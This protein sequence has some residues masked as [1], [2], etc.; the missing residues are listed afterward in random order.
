M[1][2][3]KTSSHST[4]TS[5]ILNKYSHLFTPIIK[6]A[7]EQQ[8][9]LFPLAAQYSNFYLPSGVIKN[10]SDDELGNFILDG[11]NINY[12]HELLTRIL[13]NPEIHW[14]ASIDDFSFTLELSKST[15]KKMKATHKRLMQIVDVKIKHQVGGELSNLYKRFWLYEFSSGGEIR[16]HFD[17]VDKEDSKGANPREAEVMRSSRISFRLSSLGFDN[18]RV[19]LS[20]LRGASN[21]EYDKAVK[22]MGVAKK[23]TTQGAFVTRCDLESKFYGLPFVFLLTED[24]Y[25]NLVHNAVFPDCTESTMAESYY[26]G[27]HEN[28]THFI[29]Y[30]VILGLIKK[31]VISVDHAMGLV[32]L[33]KMERRI[34]PSKDGNGGTLISEL[35]KLESHYSRLRFY[36][37]RVFS[38]LPVK[39]ALKLARHKVNRVWEH[40]GKQE[41][42][43]LKK[44]LDDPTYHINL[45]AEQVK[46][47]YFTLLDKL[48]NIIMSPA[49][50]AETPSAMRFQVKYKRRKVG[51]RTKVAC[52][53][54]NK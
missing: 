31:G 9:R 25:P 10:L 52:K 13:Q 24:T 2:S 38:A 41:T 14:D 18:L 46:M 11:D 35:N 50:M 20:W 16:F 32:Q 4:V 40:L 48:Q 43:Q 5:S 39:V 34:L 45:E 30:D 6:L 8:E 1:K 15:W 37:P 22:F 36:S 53:F 28:L 27:E 29:G 17:P 47:K 54:I 3:K 12:A 19:F 51:K 7:P 23:G 42:Q 21:D 49:I 26:H 33:C 44:V